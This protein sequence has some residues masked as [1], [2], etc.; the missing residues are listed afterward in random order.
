DRIE[1]REA[2]RKSEEDADVVLGKRFSFKYDPNI[3]DFEELE[4]D[5]EHVEDDDEGRGGGG[6]AMRGFMK[7]HCLR[8]GEARHAIKRIRNDLRGEEEIA[9]AAVNLAREA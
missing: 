4:S 5:H 8:N 1:P 2:A 9:S 6:Y 7:D 3:S